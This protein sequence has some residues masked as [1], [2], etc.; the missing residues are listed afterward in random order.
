MYYIEQAIKALSKASLY[1]VREH[2][3]QSMQT[4]QFLQNIRKPTL[5]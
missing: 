5:K 2:L 4:L 3:T 1:G